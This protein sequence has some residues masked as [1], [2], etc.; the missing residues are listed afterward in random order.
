[1]RKSV[2]IL[3]M[4]AGFLSACAFEHMDKGLAALRGRDLKTAIGYL[5][6]PDNQQEIAGNKV[7][8]W[9]RSYTATTVTPVTTYG[10]GSFFGMNGPTNYTGS[11]VSYV[12]Q[13]GTYSCVLK[14]ITNKD[15]MI[16]DSQYDGDLGGCGKYG[17]AL[18]KAAQALT[19]P[20]AH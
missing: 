5:G 18:N 19:P 17:D 1:M 20:V 15:D 8:T 6:Y 14:I 2:L 7:Y 12:P 3:A 10:S 13:T 16:I 4:M 9:G 11:T